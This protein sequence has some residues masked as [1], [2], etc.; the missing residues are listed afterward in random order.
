MKALNDPALTLEAVA[1]HFEQWRRNKRPGERIPE[2]LWNE[3]ASLVGAYSASKVTRTLRLSAT[4]LNKRR[5]GI[6]TVNRQGSGNSKAAFVEVAPEAIEQTLRPSST[7]AWME[8][9]RPDGLRLRIG[10]GSG[11]DLLA[12]LDRFVEGGTCCS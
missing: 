5:G 1:R 8:L 6:E 3:A 12:V 2:R 7:T 4:D 9:E 11:A 10:P